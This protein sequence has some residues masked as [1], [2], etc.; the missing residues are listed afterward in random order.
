MIHVIAVITANPSK[1]EEFRV[2]SR[3]RAAVRAGQGCIEYGPAIDADAAP[4]VQAKIG[5]THSSS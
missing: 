3:Q 1:R 4:P 2:F 5:P